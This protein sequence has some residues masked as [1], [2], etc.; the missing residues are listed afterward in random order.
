[1]NYCTY[2]RKKRGK[3]EFEE[4]GKKKGRHKISRIWKNPRDTGALIVVTYQCPSTVC[5]VFIFERGG[6]GGG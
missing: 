3:R 4:G 5:A 2:E 6:G 1:M